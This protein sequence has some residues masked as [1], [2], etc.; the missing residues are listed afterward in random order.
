[1]TRLRI[2]CGLPKKQQKL[3][4]MRYKMR[5]ITQVVKDVNKPTK[6]KMQ[7]DYTLENHYPELQHYYMEKV[8]L[9]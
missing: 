9:D 3:I 7:M 4:E 6:V 1:M 8:H 5:K 2:H